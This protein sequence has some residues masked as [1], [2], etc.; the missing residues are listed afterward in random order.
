MGNLHS[1]AQAIPHAL[2]L[3]TPRLQTIARDL[4][5]AR[6]H[7]AS[8]EGEYTLELLQIYRATLRP[9]TLD[10]RSGQDRVFSRDDDESSSE[11][12]SSHITLEPELE[13]Y[14][15]ELYGNHYPPWRS[16]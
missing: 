16:L 13:D 14:I 5:E 10:L 6:A 2:D 8:L 4:A 12:A 7:V 1:L 15:N 3:P 11:D 9:H